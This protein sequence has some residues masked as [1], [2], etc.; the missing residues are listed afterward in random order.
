[1]QQVGR[2][3][4]PALL[5]RCLG[6]STPLVGGYNLN[7]SDALILLREKEPEFPGVIRAIEGG[8]IWRFSSLV[9][10]SADYV[11]SFTTEYL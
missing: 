10:R 2:S 5:D 3:F 7:R 4:P 11:R 9:L 1:V 6:T 8:V